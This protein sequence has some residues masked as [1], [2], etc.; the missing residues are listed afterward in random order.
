[1][2]SQELTEKNLIFGASARAES[3]NVLERLRVFEALC[4]FPGG[5]A[6]DL[7][8]G[9]GSYVV[10]LAKRFNR[11]IGVDVLPRAL[12]GAR[13]NAP[14]NVEF[15]CATLEDV[16]LESE[17]I[18]AAF[19]V[20]VLDHVN[21]VDRSLAELKRVLKS[22][23]KAY[24]SVPNALFPFETHPVR[25]SGRFFHPWMFPFLNWTPFHD[26]FATARI[27]R[28]RKLSRL[29]ES[30]G[31]H[32]VASDYIIVPL[33]Y[34]FKFMRPIIG[35]IGRTL[36]RPLIGVSLVFVIEKK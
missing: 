28:K 6:A 23:S 17:S 18:D 2:H 20:E 25:I 16:P 21:S 12:D 19:L 10:E 3:R 24:V 35:I 11:V 27:F 22:G 14:S 36:F 31:L 1:M 7:G 26:A 33:E 29:F 13:L 5:M 8:C 34:R 15:R 30:I 9:Q 32:V 4:P